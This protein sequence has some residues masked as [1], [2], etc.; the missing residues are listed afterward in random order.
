MRRAERW[1][2]R[3]LT[4]GGV[5]G[6]A[7]MV[8]GVALSAVWGG[9]STHEPVVSLQQIVRVL[10]HRPIDPVGLSALGIVTLVVTPLVAVAGAGTAFYLDGDRRF[11]VIAAIVVA[12][13]FLSLRLGRP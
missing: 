2:A 11:A 9:Y 7:L 12:A 13:L 5:T 4:V 8:V 3:V 1:A 6:V 10:S